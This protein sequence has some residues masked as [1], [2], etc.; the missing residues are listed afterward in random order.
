MLNI[1]DTAG[2]EEYVSLRDNQ[3]R[4]GEGFLIV[5][6]VT[7]RKSFQEIV[8]FHDHI[9]R[10]KDCYHAPCVLIGN[11]SD[12]EQSRAVTFEEGQSLAKELGL[13]FYETSAKYRKN[14]DIVFQDIVKQVM[15]E[16]KPK[17]KKKESQQCRMM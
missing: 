5:Y 9:L 15:K 11:K 14:V 17:A 13:P 10:V 1:L 2:Q 6:S 3:Y 8:S 7:D 4:E 16:K 12:M